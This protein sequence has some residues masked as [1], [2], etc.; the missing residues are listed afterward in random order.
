MSDHGDWDEP[1]PIDIRITT[2]PEQVIEFLERLTDDD[3]F[4]TRYEQNTLELLAEYGIHLPPQELPEGI[5]A[6]PR[7]MLASA[8]TELY[9]ARDRGDDMFGFLGWGMVFFSFMGLRS[10]RSFRSFRP[11]S[12]EA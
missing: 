11:P 10:F 1:A 7:E 5:K 2:T 8:R 9:A 6:P 4:R 3:D 12:G